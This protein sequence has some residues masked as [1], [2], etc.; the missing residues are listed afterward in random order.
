MI[1][2]TLK[3]LLSLLA[4][5]CATVPGSALAATFPSKPIHIIVP[6]SAGTGTDLN[7]RAIAH[8][9]TVQTGQPVVVFNKPGAGGIIGSTEVARAPADGYTVL[10]TSNAHVANLFLVKSLPFDPQRDFTPVS[11]TRRLPSLIVART[12]LNV[13]TLSDL[14]E[15]A[16]RSPHKISFAA[17]TSAGRIGMELYQQMTGVKLVHVPYKSNTA[18]LTDLMGGHVDVMFVDA[19]NSLP[20]IRDGRVV[21]LAA[22]GKTRL[23]VL[24]E[25]PT[26]AEAGLAGFD[27]ASWTGIW[28]RKGTPPEAVAFLNRMAGKAAAA[29]RDA[30]EAS[31]TQV[32][33]TTQD[34][35]AKFVD[36]E[37]QLW[38]RV[39]AAAKIEP[40]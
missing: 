27:M 39:T 31:G 38:K 25:V 24:P 21:A 5:A 19:F 29:E 7:A 26:A 10:A 14:T 32:F 30:V 16:K 18:A 12:G 34:E 28:V 22:T 8:E 11:G 36:S 35:F 17:G 37:V 2:G 15:L 20:Q 33:V 1:N 13:K 23:K 9:I 40:E 3:L 4:C 6:W